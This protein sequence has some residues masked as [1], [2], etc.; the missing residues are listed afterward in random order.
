M[1]H[2]LWSLYSI[3]NVCFFRFWLFFLPSFHF[4]SMA[5]Y[6][7][8]NHYS[9]FLFPL[10]KWQKKKTVENNIITIYTYCMCLS[11]ESMCISYD[12][13]CLAC[14]CFQFRFCWVMRPSYSREHFYSRSPSYFPLRIDVHWLFL[15]L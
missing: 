15:L 6:R 2:T 12:Y 11:N 3:L 13:T 14:M 8:C 5:V 9:L 10:A 4:C 1:I 7:V